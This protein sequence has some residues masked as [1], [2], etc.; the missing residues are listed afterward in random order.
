M[1]RNYCDFKKFYKKKPWIFVYRIRLV[2]LKGP[3]YEMEFKYV[4]KN[5]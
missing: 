2:D 4:E 1:D 5:G 3:D